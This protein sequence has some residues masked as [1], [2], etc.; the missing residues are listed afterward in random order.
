MPRTV[1]CK[2]FEGS[3]TEIQAIILPDPPKRPEG[4]LRHGLFAKTL[5]FG[6]VQEGRMYARL[7]REF[8]RQF[9]PMNLLEET[10]IEKMA[11]ALW[12]VRQ[13]MRAE[14]EGEELSPRA[15][16]KIVALEREFHRA[17]ESLR[18]VKAMELD[19]LRAYKDWELQKWQMERED[20]RR[21]ADGYE[22]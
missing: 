4:I 3:D 18:R 7:R 6:T 20:K 22:R 16:A 13:A 5:H 15:Q 12:K 8:R 14:K 19:R 9:K 21:A 17:H 2:P 11:V 10:L 1:T